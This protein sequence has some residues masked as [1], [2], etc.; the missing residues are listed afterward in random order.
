MQRT[1]PSETCTSRLPCI[2]KNC[3]TTRPFNSLR[4][5]TV[6]FSAKKTAQSLASRVTAS[7]SHQQLFKN[8]L[9]N[10]EDMPDVIYE[11][12]TNE[13][14]IYYETNGQSEASMMIPEDD[15]YFTAFST[16]VTIRTERPVNIAIETNN[17][18][19]ENYT[20]K[21]SNESTP[22]NVRYQQQ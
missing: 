7:N 22:M 3:S 21:D 14:T 15:A 4:H 9:A 5:E 13:E 2:L 12:N 11:N 18:N 10:K 8:N 17:R 20:V 19:L 1:V 16:T 6:S